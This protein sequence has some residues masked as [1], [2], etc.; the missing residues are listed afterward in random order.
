MKDK[1]YYI[2]MDGGGT[3]TETVLFDGSGNLLCRDMEAGSNPLDAGVEVAAERLSGAI[4]RV[5]REAGVPVCA[6]YG[7]IAGALHA[8]VPL[9]RAVNERCGSEVGSIR[10]GRDTESIIAA[11]LGKQAGC[12]LI[13]GTGAGL[14]VKNANGELN[15]IGGWGYLLDTGGSGYKL[16][17]DA[18]YMALRALDGRDGPTLL[19]AL[20][21][22][23]LGKPV[24]QAIPQIYDGGRAYIAS[25]ARLVFEARNAGDAA[26]ETVFQDGAR[27]LAELVWAA[28]P[29][30][31]APYQVI[32]NGGI[33]IHFPE[34]RDAIASYLPE[35]A[36]LTP[37]AFP[38]IYGCARQA[39]W[40]DGTDATPEFEQRFCQ[41]YDAIVKR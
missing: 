6:V 2:A 18:I 3:K 26:A 10:I 9:L 32:I 11:M 38:V 21:E 28:D 41:Q 17:R 20:L 23:E 7:G 36:T 16:G 34:Y 19:T 39:L 25:F 8:G 14:L 27:A 4:R 31:D 40:M 22:R 29:Y 13:A 5:I 15:T 35:R 37:L 30:F 24:S 1:K 12:S 33:A